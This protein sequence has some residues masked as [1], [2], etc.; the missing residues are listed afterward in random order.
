MRRSQRIEN[1]EGGGAGFWC[2]YCTEFVVTVTYVSFYH[3]L[4]LRSIVIPYYPMPSRMNFY[5]RVF[6]NKT[7]LDHLKWDED[8]E[9]LLGAQ[10]GYQQHHQGTSGRRCLGYTRIPRMFELI[11]TFVHNYN[12]FGFGRSTSRSHCSRVYLGTFLAPTGAKDSQIRKD[13]DR[14]FRKLNF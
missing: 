14:L 10:A 6:Q 1:R 9:G 5:F 3:V 8:G 13:I 2:R 12:I 4:K 11:R 7:V